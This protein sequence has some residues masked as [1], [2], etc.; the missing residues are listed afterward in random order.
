[1]ACECCQPLGLGIV[2]CTLLAQHEL[3]V[4]RQAE[5]LVPLVDDAVVRGVDRVPVGG[6]AVGRVGTR[7]ESVDGVAVAV[8]GGGG[9][10]WGGKSSK[11]VFW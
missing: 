7:R 3:L 6:G 2:L 8:K 5:D 10:V 4:A 11:H 1:M 9:G